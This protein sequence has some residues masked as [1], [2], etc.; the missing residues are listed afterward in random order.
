M[1]FIQIKRGLGFKKSRV[2]G[3]SWS[4]SAGKQGHVRKGLGIAQGTLLGT[5]RESEPLPIRT[6]LS[7]NSRESHYS[8]DA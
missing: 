4:W 5:A 6:F 8:T 3:I 1:D 7:I 2:G